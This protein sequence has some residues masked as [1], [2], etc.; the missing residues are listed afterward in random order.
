[1]LRCVMLRC[2]MLRYVERR[3]LNDCFLVWDNIAEGRGAAVLSLCNTDIEEALSKPRPYNDKDSPN[4]RRSLDNPCTLCLYIS[5]RTCNICTSLPQN[6]ESFELLS[7]FALPKE[8]RRRQHLAGKC[9]AS[10][11][12]LLRLL[13][14]S[15]SPYPFFLSENIA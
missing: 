4:H 9:S 12:S 13:L 14:L 7:S 3:T 6:K 11:L 10:L 5:V 2:V 1:M 8:N 15:F